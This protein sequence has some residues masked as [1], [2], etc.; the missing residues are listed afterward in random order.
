MKREDEDYIEKIRQEFIERFCKAA[1]HED[2]EEQVK[3]MKQCVALI[4]DF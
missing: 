1:L 4:G 2:D 3:H